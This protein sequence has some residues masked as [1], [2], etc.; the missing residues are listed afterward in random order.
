MYKTNFVRVTEQGVTSLHDEYPLVQSHDIVIRFEVSQDGKP[1]NA[2][3][4][5]NGKFQ[6]MPVFTLKA[7]DPMASSYVQH[8][9]EMAE[10][11]GVEQSKVISAKS[12]AEAM[13]RWK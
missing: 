2:Q 10:L 9:A 12:T 6:V 3:V 1:M 4:C 7:T 8:W 11:N 5:P 13:K